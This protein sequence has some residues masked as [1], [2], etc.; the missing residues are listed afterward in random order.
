MEMMLA[1]SRARYPDRRYA[2]TTQIHEDDII[3]TIP[4]ASSRRVGAG[5]DV[6]WGGRHQTVVAGLVSYLGSLVGKDR[7]SRRVHRRCA[8]NPTECH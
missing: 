5:D 2:I 3:A 7:C 4:I 8:G 1:A 6:N